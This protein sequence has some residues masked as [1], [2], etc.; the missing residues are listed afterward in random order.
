[1]SRNDS[2]IN[3]I[4]NPMHSE[5]ILNKSRTGTSPSLD[6]R[7]K[8]EPLTVMAGLYKFSNSVPK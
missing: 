4:S 1:M 2:K 5:E 6:D 3:F 8:T 7:G